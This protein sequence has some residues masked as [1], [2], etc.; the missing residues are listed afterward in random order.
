[1]RAPIVQSSTSYIQSYQF[2]LIRKGVKLQVI[3]TTH[4]L[5]RK[6]MAEVAA[7][8]IER[9]ASMVSVAYKFFPI[10]SC[11]PPLIIES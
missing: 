10:R 3:K 8:G 6:K 9:G 11:P 1:M 5:G 4:Q 7:R 2:E